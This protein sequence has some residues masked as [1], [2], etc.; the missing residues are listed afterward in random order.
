MNSEISHPGLPRAVEIGLSIIMLIVAAPILAVAAILIKLDS[1]GPILFKQKRVGENGKDFILLKLR[2]MRA[3]TDGA[4][5]TASFDARITRVGRLLRRTKLDEL[6]ELWNIIRGEMCIVGPRPEVP[7]LVDL[8]DH[9]WK[10][11]LTVNPGLTDPV[12]LRLRNEEQLLAEAADEERF[13]EDVLQP[14]KLRGYVDFLRGRTWRTDVKIIFGTIKAIV[15][16]QTALL[17]TNE[18]LRCQLGK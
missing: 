17:P 11:I 6:P 4:P 5:V 3:N 7:E 13:Y 10:E 18:E 14:Y 9:L 15:F 8:D 16:P 12:T 2:T 1:K